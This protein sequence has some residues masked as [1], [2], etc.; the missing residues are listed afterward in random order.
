MTTYRVVHATAYAYEEAVT[1]SYG[2]VYLLPRNTESQRVRTSRVMVSPSPRDE[3][4]RRDL[5]GN[6]VGYFHVERAHTEL[7]ITATSEVEVLDG[8]AALPLEAARTLADIQVAVTALS[9]PERLV[10]TQF[11]LDSERATVDDQV[12]GY[13][14]PSF[15]PDRPVGESLVDLSHRIHADFEF[16][17]DAT[18]VTSTIDDLFESKAGV[19]QDFAHLAVAC[20][21]SVGLPARYVSGY[22]ETVPP[23]GR[24]RLAGADVSHAWAGAYLP[25]VGWIDIDP[26]NDQFVD[27]RYITNAWGRDYADVAPVKGVIY[28]DGSLDEM[29]VSV[30]VERLSD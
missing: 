1:S 7:V 21:R 5:F 10:A 12:R 6:R 30:D 15:A 2:Q 14:E 23:P 16:A 11:Q 13:A 18:K 17:A 28:S 26:T 29:T 3:R 9:G 22:L 19:C 4:E 25:E 8:P 20:I 24:P 27:N